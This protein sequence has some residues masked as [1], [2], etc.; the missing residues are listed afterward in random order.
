M[1]RLLEHIIRHALFEQ[2]TDWDITIEFSQPDGD[3]PGRVLRY[4]TA[5]NNA[6]KV[7]AIAGVAVVAKARRGV[8]NP[9]SNISEIIKEIVRMMES[10]PGHVYG[11]SGKYDNTRYLY[12]LAR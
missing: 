6:E 9:T 10:N 1:S 12:V 8:K 4:Q 11:K 7:G 2:T 5:Q 3:G